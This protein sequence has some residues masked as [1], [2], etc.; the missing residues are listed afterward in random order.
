MRERSNIVAK[1]LNYEIGFTADTRQLQQAIDAAVKSLQKLGT[2]PAYGLTEELS[3]AS[4]SALDLSNNLQKAINQNTGKLDLIDFEKNLKDSGKSLS[5][6]AEELSRLGPI[7]QQAFLNVA[8]AIT[9]AE[10]PLKRS[11]KLLSELW[12]T[13]KNTARWQ[14]TSSALHG[15]VG[16]LSTAYGYSKSLD[17]SL[18]NIR[19]VSGQSAEEMKEFAEQ[20]NNAA[21]ALSTTTTDYT[22][23][24]LIY[25]QQGLDEQ[26]VQERTEATIKMANVTGESAQQVSDQ[27]TAIWNNFED[28]S[29]SLTYYAD[30]ITALGAATA[31]SADEISAGLEKFA[32]IADNVGL[33]YEYATAA[34]ATVTAK[35]RQ[36][37]DVVGTAYK[38]LF[39]RIQG[40]QLGETLEDGTTLNKYSEALKT[41][42]ISIFE[43]NGELKAMDKILDEMGNKWSQLSKD[44]QV[45][46]AQTVAGV[47]QYNQLMALMSNW[48]YFQENLMVARNSEGELE[49]QAEIYAES[50]E[51]A[52]NRVKAA[53]EDIYDSIINPDLFIQLDNTIVPVLSTIANL[54]D[55]MGGLSGAISITAYA[56]TRLY[57]DKLSAG[58]VN[59]ADN[60][61]IL[62]GA[63]QQSSREMQHIAA[64]EAENL[65]ISSIANKEEQV[66]LQLMRDEVTLRGQINQL[67]DVLTEKDRVR[68]SQQQGILN[69]FKDQYVEL[70]K[71]QSAAERNV[72]RRETDDILTSSADDDWR[73][74]IAL[75][76]DDWNNNHAANKAINLQFNTQDAEDVLQ[77]LTKQLKNYTGQSAEMLR[78][79]QA[80]SSLSDEQKANEQVLRDLINSTHLTKR[81]FS[82]LEN[83]D[84]TKLRKWFESLSAESVELGQKIRVLEGLLHDLGVDD[85]SITRYIAELRELATATDSCRQAGEAYNQNL[86]ETSES[87]NETSERTL[88]WADKIVRASN[89]L[90]Q[91]TMSAQ[92][93]QSLGSIITNEDISIVDKITQSLMA[94]TM[95]LPLIVEHAPKIIMSTAAYKSLADAIY[96]VAIAEVNGAAASEA[97]NAGFIKRQIVLKAHNIL[98]KKHT[99][100]QIA[101]MTATQ[102][103]NAILLASSPYLLALAAAV[104]AVV[105]AYDH[106]TISAKEAKKEIEEVNQA[107]EEEVQKLNE[108]NNSLKTTTN[109][110]KELEEQGSL[111]LVEQEEL[112]KLRRT[113]E[114]LKAQLQIQESLNKETKK[115]QLRTLAKNTAYEIS[116]LITSAPKKENVLEQH[117]TNKL[118]KFEKG[119]EEYAKALQ[120]FED[121]QSREQD[122]I[123]EWAK[124]NAEQLQSIE[125]NYATLATGVV[126][127]EISAENADIDNYQDSLKKLR[128]IQYSEEEY[129]KFF[130][131]PVLDSKAMNDSKEELIIAL[132]NEKKDLDK[133]L[134]K[135]VKNQLLLSGISIEDFIS[136]LQSEMTDLKNF[137]QTS[138]LKDVQ[139]FL[140]NLTAEDIH[141]MMSL[142][143]QNFDNFSDFYQKY[144]EVKD[145]VSIPVML[146]SARD[147]ALVALQS[148][149][150]G[151]FLTDE[152]ILELQQKFAG[153]FDLSQLNDMS[154]YDQAKEIG[155]AWMNA[156]FPE[157]LLKLNQEK[158]ASMKKELLALNGKIH[159]GTAT[160][161]EQII[162][163]KLALDVKEA[164]KKLEGISDFEL[165][166]LELEVIGIEG[167]LAQM[168]LLS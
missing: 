84:F 60:I 119:T 19:I 86:R 8:S 128:K 63:A 43:Q 144:L 12:V 82:D 127:N 15:F 109:R 114:L 154:M 161:E 45:A 159:R 76:I 42:G 68:L 116:P 141:I 157:D 129:L 69:L 3:Q 158:L 95:S 168:A 27:M 167:I 17:H 104:T 123:L 30:V 146:E 2:N 62:A 80:W 142:D 83:A 138:G 163:A 122:K 79:R 102:K 4:K 112:E 125:D 74:S 87:L 10:L 33:S 21:K 7:G 64:S 6:Y 75:R 145:G 53:A 124:E 137:L 28:G 98:L 156:A 72:L 118:S 136:N 103:F 26:Q 81:A 77:D 120:N 29:Q 153:I 1:K 18:N 111:T 113:E 162:Q 39:A 93:L 22:D 132:A 135:E 54:I 126:N 78:L 140:D 5:Q 49:R 143:L 38:T 16:A 97:V 13:M 85:A 91:L 71:Q 34:L 35:T 117:Y 130:I 107:Y 108:L 101:A 65:Q 41:V 90:I 73:Q 152:Q 166:P 121:F 23:A 70:S 32:A 24:A 100:A 48:D 67:E 47:R 139:I 149:S 155:E 96:E 40:L 46:L 151:E 66:R 115:R 131:Q 58:L 31:S 134:N 133:Y 44:Q 110:I 25:Y 150:T 9:Q 147:S 51:A 61:R 36:S 99:A 106:F 148:L 37:A 55:G 105:V 164:E 50:W 160:D 89:V 11:N 56:F 92:A 165:D 52:R 94:L 59:M 20:A 14:L 88:G 57:S